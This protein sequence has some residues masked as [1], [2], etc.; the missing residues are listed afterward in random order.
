M[1]WAA[2]EIPTCSRP[3]T[4]QVIRRREILTTTV[5][6]TWWHQTI[7]VA[8]LRSGSITA[9]I[10]QTFQRPLSVLP[11]MLLLRVTL[12][13]ELT[14][15]TK[16]SLLTTAAQRRHWIAAFLRTVYL[17]LEQPS[18]SVQQSTRAEIAPRTSVSRSR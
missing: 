12:W 16:S 17:L 11:P 15:V 5:G 7:M 6:L 3:A 8:T 14:L 13:V 18:C 1:V 4:G 2:L 9:L 10:Y